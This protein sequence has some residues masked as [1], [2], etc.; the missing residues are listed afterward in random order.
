M[1]R[2]AGSGAFPFRGEPSA[3]STAAPE[4]ENSFS[5]AA[6]QNGAEPR[7]AGAS[8]ISEASV[9]QPPSARLNPRLIRAPNA[10]TLQLPVTRYLA[11]G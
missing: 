2:G 8:G 1:R 10:G 7:S 11:N 3:A 5:S 4:M 6:S 9:R